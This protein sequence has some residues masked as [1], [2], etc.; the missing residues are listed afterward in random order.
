[1]ASVVFTAYQRPHY[2]RETLAS[3]ANVRGIDN[4]RLYLHLEPSELMPEMLGVIKDS[5]LPI[6]TTLNAKHLG[7]L[8]NPWTAL[9]TV[10]SRTGS[11]FTVLAEEDV[12]V[13]DDV[14]EYF[15]D[16]VMRCGPQRALGVCA[17]SDRGAGDPD[18]IYLAHHFSPLIWGTWGETWF[19][20]IR[21]DWD[22]DYSTN[23]GIPGV[24]A[25]WDY[26]LVRISNRTNL[27]FMHPDVSRSRHIG[28]FGG[29]HTT[30][31]T[32]AS[33]SSPTF[34]LHR[35]PIRRLRWR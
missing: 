1:M 2:L 6:E 21:D 22:K 13:S 25:G 24:E 35:A 9:N 16:A 26:Q 14:L 10:F 5:G 18:K 29:T 34:Q 27:P 15:H 20:H 31:E 3:W 23:N 7:V 12:I 8:V 11:G 30:P 33:L 19:Q 17:F 28:E 4:V 32:W